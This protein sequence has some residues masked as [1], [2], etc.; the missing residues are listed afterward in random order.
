MV[1]G[2]VTGVIGHSVAKR[3][4]VGHHVSGSERN[5]D[6]RHSSVL[7]GSDAAGCSCVGSDPLS[8][9]QELALATTQG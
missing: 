2:R 3:S 8:G 5:E 7:G 9:E 6:D 1:A 4:P